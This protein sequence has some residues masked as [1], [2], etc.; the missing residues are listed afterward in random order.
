MSFN[1]ED[2]VV[3]LGDSPFLET[4][5]DKV[6]YVLDKYSSIG[7]NRVIKIYKTNFHIFTDATM[8]PITNYYTSIPTISLYIYG[9]LIL[10]KNKELYNTFSIN[11]KK[12]NSVFKNNELAWCGFTHDY[13]ISYCIMKKYKN[14][15]LIGSADFTKG[16]HFS[17][18]DVFNPSIKLQEQSKYF[19]ENICTKKINIVTC[20]PDSYLNVPFCSIDEL[21]V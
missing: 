5:Q 20:N 19:V 8:I 2:T 4:V 10:K 11:V 9:D 14:I 6:M 12:E 3:L 18:E 17:N 21:L 16:T 13:A 7:I 1:I 15:I